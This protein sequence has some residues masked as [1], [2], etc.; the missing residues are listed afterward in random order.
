L[1]PAGYENVT[2]RLGELLAIATA[3]L[4]F[5][6]DGSFF[7]PPRPLARF[8]PT[9]VGSRCTVMKQRAEVR[10][11]WKKCRLVLHRRRSFSLL[12]RAYS[13]PRTRGRKLV[14]RHSVSSADRRS[15][16]ARLARAFR[17]PF[18]HFF[19]PRVNAPRVLK[20]MESFLFSDFQ[21]QVTPLVV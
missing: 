5:A 21:Y 16:Y 11:V 4:S 10:R 6:L 20:E 14:V 3:P 1:M 17:L 7:T 18:E 15:R 13:T 9:R 8:W 12:V 19:D 2:W